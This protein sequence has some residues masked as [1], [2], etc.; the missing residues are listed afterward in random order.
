MQTIAMMHHRNQTFYDVC[1]P[2]NS[3]SS[4]GVFNADPKS[5][6]LFSAQRLPN[7][8]RRSKKRKVKFSHTRYR[9]LGRS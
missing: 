3:L 4:L 1:L 9:A 2:V 7:T 8:P 5:P 6:Q